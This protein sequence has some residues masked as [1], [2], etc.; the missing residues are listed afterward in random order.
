MIDKENEVYT[1]VREKVLEAFPEV[2]MDS[3]YQIAPSEF[4]HV[5][6]FQSDTFTPAEYLDTRLIPKYEASTFTA[7][8]SS[9]KSGHKKT[10]CKEIMAVICD[11]M[12]LM[13]YRRIICTSVPNINDSSIYRLTAR[14]TALVD[15][16]G[17]YR[18]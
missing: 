17:F 6:L 11:A 9:N 10:E 16:N 15:E 14:F 7:E 18:R 12:S 2:D 13:N 8:V 3:S 5:S 4:P 1:R